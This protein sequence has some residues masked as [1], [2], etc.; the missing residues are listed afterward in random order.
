MEENDFLQLTFDDYTSVLPKNVSE[1]KVHDKTMLGQYL[2][3]MVNRINTA[4]D[5][6]KAQLEESLKTGYS[7]LSGRAVW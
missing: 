6:E 4:E 3:I 1:V 7:L 2:K 5:N